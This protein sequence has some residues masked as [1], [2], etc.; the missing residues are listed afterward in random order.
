M[1]SAKIILDS[2]AETTKV[3]LTTM[4]LTYPRFVHSQFMTHRVFSRNS[5]SSRAIP[6]SKIIRQVEE[7]PVIPVYWG[8]NQSG[9]Q[10][11]EE[12]NFSE[13]AKAAAQWL[14]ARDVAIEQVN[15]LIELNV[16]KQ[17]VNRLLEPWMWITVIV[18]ATE[19]E[20]FFNQRCHKDPQPEIQK[21]ALM[22]KE[23]YDSNI[24]K[25]LK[26]DEWHRPY[27]NDIDELRKNLNEA[28]I[29][30]ISVARC[31]RVSYLSHDGKRDINKDLELYD[32]LLEGF[33]MSPL[34]HVARVYDPKEELDF[35][36][37]FGESS[38]WMQYRKHIP[39]EDC[40]KP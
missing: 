22:A 8:K 15:R 4:E 20:N 21:I 18:S 7:D 28:Q 27:T 5:S 23:Q 33:H 2:V 12:L 38:G 16:H 11:N 39:G 31:A 26:V 32:K 19:W 14:S 34:E 1:Y 13:S 24:P 3:R 10:A 9:M 35:G 29:T 40:F 30:C 17:I 25:I 6:I 37:N 36:S